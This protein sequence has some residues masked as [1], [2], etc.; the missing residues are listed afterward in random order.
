MWCVQLP[1]LLFPM[2]M[3]MKMTPTLPVIRGYCGAIQ[4]VWSAEEGEM[5]FS[6]SPFAP[7][8]LVSRDW[9]GRLVP[10]RPA[11]CPQSG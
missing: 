5:I 3:T 8:S 9:F 1:V 7:E 4:H 11:H 6:L 2:T 10:R